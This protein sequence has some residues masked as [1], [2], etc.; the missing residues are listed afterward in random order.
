MPHSAEIEHTAKIS[1]IAQNLGAEQTDIEQLLS[2]IQEKNVPPQQWSALLKQAYRRLQI[3]RGKLSNTGELTASE[4]ETTHLINQVNSAI[5]PGRSLSFDKAS[6]ALEIA[7]ERCVER[8]DAAEVKALIHGL[9]ALLAAA[10]Q[11]YQSAEKHYA[12]AAMTSRLSIR[13]QW[14]YQIDRALVLEDFGRE[15]GDKPALEKSISLLQDE[16]LN[17]V[18]AE[19][20]PAEWALT[21]HILGTV[22]GVLGQRQGGTRNLENSAKAFAASLS[23]RDRKQEPLQWAET[24]NS[25]GNTLGMLAHRQNDVDMLGKS[26]EAFE[27]ALEERTRDRALQSWAITQNNLAAVLQSLGQRNKDTRMLKR[28]VNVY[29]EVLQ[30]WTKEKVPLDWAATLNN[31]G[32]ALRIM[33]ELRKGPRTLEQAV[34]AFNSALSERTRDRLPQEWAMTQNNLGA[35]L[36]KLAEREANPET[37]EKAIAAYENALKEWTRERAPMA[38]TMTMANLGVARRTLAEA[39]ADGDAARKAVEEL[40]AVSEAFREASHAQYSEFSIDELAKAKKVASAL[41]H[42]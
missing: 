32:T 25:F 14:Q 13:L 29:K 18:T 36:H 12:Q 7:N 19:E 40:E 6:R 33:G 31:L 30:E 20:N 5:Q 10:T 11:D 9:Q 2:Y 16:I 38:W 21:Q 26:I 3:L 39:T 22:C 34:A 27:H 4:V 8:D 42:A 1:S 41:V 37:L 17:L 24:Q 35:A 28:A 15:F 23:K